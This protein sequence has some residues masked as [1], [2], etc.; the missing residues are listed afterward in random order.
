MWRRRQRCYLDVVCSYLIRVLARVHYSPIEIQYRRNGRRHLRQVRY[1]C[2]A[3]LRLS[4]RERIR[5]DIH[6][7]PR[8]VLTLYSKR[9]CARLYIVHVCHHGVCRIDIHD[10]T[11]ILYR[12]DRRQYRPACILIRC[13]GQLDCRLVALEIYRMYREGHLSCIDEI[14]SVYGVDEHIARTRA[15]IVCPCLTCVVCVMVRVIVQLLIVVSNLDVRIY[16][17]PINNACVIVIFYWLIYG[18]RRCRRV[19]LAD[20]IVIPIRRLEQYSVVQVWLQD[21]KRNS[22]ITTIDPLTINSERSTLRR[23]RVVFPVIQRIVDILRQRHTIV[24]DYRLRLYCISR[25]IV[26]V[27]QC[28]D[29]I[30]YRRPTNGEI[31]LLA[32]LEVSNSSIGDGRSPDSSIVHIRD[33]EVHPLSQVLTIICQDIAVLLDGYTCIA[34]ALVRILKRDSSCSSIVRQALL[35]YREVEVLRAHVGVALRYD[36]NYRSVANV[37]VVLIVI[38]EVDSCCQDVLRSLIA[39]RHPR[40]RLYLRIHED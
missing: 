8:I 32:A 26:E 16:T 5:T 18:C 1:R 25:E 30:C 40:C 11:I 36:T 37:D 20:G 19:V 23:I 38:L 34:H 24:H 4:Y 28:D 13:L 2:L 33:V 15:D 35:R 29:C 6:K 39:Y 10:A 27:W 14:R 22:L 31:V 3:N 12:L 17:R 9:S 7:V 21:F